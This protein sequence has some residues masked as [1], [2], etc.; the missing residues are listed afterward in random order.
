MSVLVGRWPDRRCFEFGELS[1]I[2]IEAFPLYLHADLTPGP[3]TPN[4]FGDFGF[5]NFVPRDFDGSK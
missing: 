3:E 4:K 1:P 2:S 5:W